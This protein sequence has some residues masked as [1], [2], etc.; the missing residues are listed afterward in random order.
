[1]YRSY[2]PVKVWPPKGLTSTTDI[3]QLP[4]RSPGAVRR[5]PKNYRDFFSQNQLPANF[6]TYRAPPGT[7]HFG[8]EDG[9]NATPM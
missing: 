6:P 8:L 5:Q 1:M 2:L 9:E 4:T 7:Q 3:Q